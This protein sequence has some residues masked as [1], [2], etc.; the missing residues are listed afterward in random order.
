[1][2][3]LPIYIIYAIAVVVGIQQVE[4]KRS[5]PV[6]ASVRCQDEECRL[7]AEHFELY[8]AI[9][10]AVES[11]FDVSGKDLI[12]LM[13]SAEVLKLRYFNQEP[14]LN[15]TSLVKSLLADERLTRALKVLDSE[16]AQALV[17]LYRS[18][19][20]GRWQSLACSRWR[21][22]E[23]ELAAKR[24]DRNPQL[25]SVL[26]KVHKNFLR[27]SARKCLR[28]S[29]NSVDEN[30]SRLSSTLGR[31][32]EL[33]HREAGARLAVADEGPMSTSSGGPEGPP[34]PPVGE[35][36]FAN[37]E[38]ELCRFFKRTNATSCQVSAR[39]LTGLSLAAGSNSTQLGELLAEYGRNRLSGEQWSSPGEQL[40]AAKRLVRV[41]CRPMRPLLEQSLAAL[42]WYSSQQLI[43]ER[44]L[45]SSGLWCPSL[46]YWLEVDRLC[47]E[48]EAAAGTSFSY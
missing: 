28:Q 32:L 20:G 39:E 30:M 34:R 8:S 38:L 26:A 10:R 21:V 13:R 4:A 35:R 42:R 31:P 40:E 22:G 14:E 47:A 3:D 11:D 2:K 33:R 36:E 15:G 6:A 45:A 25:A 17:S 18:S 16:D 27:R 37:E 7:K 9:K 41:Q 29:C 23:I 46:A 5:K 48:L 43:E 19:S 1:M 24:L 12:P 44:R